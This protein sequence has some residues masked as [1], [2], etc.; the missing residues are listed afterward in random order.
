MVVVT[1]LTTPLAAAFVRPLQRLI[2]SVQKASTD[3]FYGE[4]DLHAANEF[5]QLAQNFNRLLEH[6][7]TQIQLVAAKEATNTRLLHTIMPESVVEQMKQNEPQIVNRVQQATVLVAQ[8]VGLVQLNIQEAPIT[9]LKLFDT[10]VT[11]FG[12][13]GRR[14]G[15]ELPRML[16]EQYLSVCGLTTP[17]LDHT[18]RTIHFA[19]EML[20]II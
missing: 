8:V 2:V 3:A 4:I 11:A 10:L 1:L 9:M 15:M 18:K 7:R 16:S 6:L 14:Q 20:R 5:G 19:E 12:E 13:A 17:R